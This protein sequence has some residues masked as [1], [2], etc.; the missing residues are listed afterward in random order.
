MNRLVT[1]SEASRVLGVSISTLRLNLFP[2]MV[3]S[4]RL[5]GSRSSKNQK[6]LANVKK[7]IEDTRLC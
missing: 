1:I 6:L 5:Y 2:M 3:F 7:A 4:A